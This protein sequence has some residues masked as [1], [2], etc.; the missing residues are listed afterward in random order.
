MASG[1]RLTEGFWWYTAAP[2]ACF[3]GQ[4]HFHETR[5]HPGL[6]NVNPPFQHVNPAII[7]A[8]V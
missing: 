8:T 6:I 7:E 3:E 2:E 1:L 4:T 5:P